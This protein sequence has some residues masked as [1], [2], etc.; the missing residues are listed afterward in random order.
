[1]SPTTS[2]ST[3]PTNSN[4]QKPRFGRTHDIIFSCLQ[5]SLLTIACVKSCNADER[6]SGNIPRKGTLQ[7]RQC[8]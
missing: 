3:Q 2:N 6:M 8:V 4:A 7:G 5:N 1:M